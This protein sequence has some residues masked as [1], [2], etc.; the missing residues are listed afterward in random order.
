MAK[1]GSANFEIPA[2]M[3]NFAEKSMEQARQA[4]DS[5]IA[6]TQVAV[7]TVEGQAANTRTGVKE[8]VDL[9][10]QF[11]ERNIAASFEFAQRLLHAKDAKDV[12]AIHAEYVTSQ[13]AALTDQAKELSKQAAKLAGST[14]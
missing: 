8:A 13:I 3:R 11:S 10:M 7:N 9:A 5:F 1:E 12:T 2:E 14:H 4:F 6:A